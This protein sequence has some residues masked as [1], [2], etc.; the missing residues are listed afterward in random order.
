MKDVETS[1]HVQ[2]LVV[3]SIAG[4]ILSK[5]DSNFIL[6]EGRAKG[7][8]KGKTFHGSARKTSD[9]GFPDRHL[10]TGHPL[11]WSRW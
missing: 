9:R 10:P 5:G 2:N 3:G 7:G 1:S 8:R 6:E 11:Q 4:S